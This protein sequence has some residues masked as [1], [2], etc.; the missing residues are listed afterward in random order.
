MGL[1]Y[2]SRANKQ[3]DRAYVLSLLNFARHLDSLDDC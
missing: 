1:I 2:G 3:F